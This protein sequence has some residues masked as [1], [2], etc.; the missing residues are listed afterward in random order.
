MKKQVRASGQPSPTFIRYQGVVMRAARKVPTR[1]MRLS[2]L[3]P[4]LEEVASVTMVSVRV[5]PSAIRARKP[6]CPNHPAGI[7]GFLALGKERLRIPAERPFVA[8]LVIPA[9]LSTLRGTLKLPERGSDAILPRSLQ[10]A[11]P[12]DWRGKT[13]LAAPGGGAP[14]P[15]PPPPPPPQ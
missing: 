10:A 4:G 8:P 3:T 13:S 12:R 7:G 6:C 9:L 5:V 14:S 2:Q 1:K 15:G 11:T